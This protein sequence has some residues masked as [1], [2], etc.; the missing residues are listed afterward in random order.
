MVEILEKDLVKESGLSAKEIINGLTKLGAP[1]T[2]D[3]EKL[4]IELTPNRPD[5]FF[6]TGITRALNLFYKKQIRN[7]SVKKGEYRVIVDKSVERV[8]PYTICAVVKNLKLTERKIEE[9]ILAQEKLMLTI[10]RKTRKFGMGFYPLDGLSFP[11][12][13]TMKDLSK[14]KYKP[15]NYPHEADGYEILAKHPKGIENKHILGDRKDYPV[16]LEA[17]GGVI[18]LVPIVNSDKFGKVD[19]HTTGVF[20]EVTGVDLNIIKQVLN[21][22]VCNLID[23]GGVAYSVEMKYPNKSFRSLDFRP[24]KY[25]MDLKFLNKTLGL[26]LTK[27]KVV[28]LLKRMG[29]LTKGNFV[30]VAPYRLDVM[31]FVDI[32][33]DVVIAYGYENLEPEVPQIYSE[34]RLADY[35]KKEIARVMYGMGFLEAKSLILTNRKKLESWGF[36]GEETEN[37]ASSECEV[38]RPTLL[39]SLI[40][41]FVTNK[42]AGLPQ[43]IFEIGVVCDNGKQKKQLAFGVTD[44]KIDFSTAKG[45]LQTLLKEFCS[46]YKIEKERAWGFDNEQSC[47]VLIK[48]ETT[49]KYRKFGVFGLLSGKVKENFGLKTDIYLCVLDLPFR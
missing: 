27:A 8:R 49:N 9:L 28:E 42:M 21:L 35:E 17:N 33:E 31:H 45:Y 10:G 12:R 44:E 5:L 22:V 13:Y 11:I 19:Q 16:F 39:P 18:C 3:G 29:F 46:G 7:Y 32:V 14:I 30:L 4:I 47:C 1:T 43:K 41:V 34:G 6:I 2:K 23:M 15:L 24:K 40:D 37:P 20:I 48:D 26:N 25:P 38:I 36:R